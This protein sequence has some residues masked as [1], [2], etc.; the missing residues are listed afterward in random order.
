MLQKSRRA[1]LARDVDHV[2]IVREPVESGGT[3]TSIGTHILKV[4]SVTDIDQARECDPLADHV[5]SIAGRAPDAVVD[6]PRL[7]RA[8]G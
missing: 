3:A 1:R 2:V 4:Q 8:V 5:D 6:G 7:A